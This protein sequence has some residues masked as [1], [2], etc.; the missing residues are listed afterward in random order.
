VELL[1]AVAILAL[2][3]GI[4][5][6]NFTGITPLE[7]LK[8][9]ARKMAGISDLVRSE[10]TG[11]RTKSY[12]EIDFVDHRYRVVMDPPQDD[13]GHY[14]DPDD[15]RLL[16]GQ[17]VKEWD[18]AFSWDELPRDVY[19]K[20]LYYSNQLFFG[21]PKNDSV[22]VTYFPDGKVM[23]YSLIL[24]G[25][26]ERGK[27]GRIFSIVVNGLSGKSEVLDYEAIPL[28]ATESDFT[29]VMG[30]DAPGGSG[31]GLSGSGNK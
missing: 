30:P 26:A 22:R 11:S 29:A 8:S 23:S 19:F 9:A 2:T 17:D 10:A 15:G 3:G 28:A 31:P 25:A 7:R 20:R 27:Q 13:F 1:I 6:M 14:I 24:Q 5:V 4:I 21:P 12:L 16:T 18:E